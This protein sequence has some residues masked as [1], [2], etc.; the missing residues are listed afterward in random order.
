MKASRFI[1]AGMVLSLPVLLG[2]CATMSKEECVAADWRVVGETDGAAGHDPQSR[3]AA[4]AKSC[5]KAG[6]VPDQTLWYQGFQVGVTRYCT[7]LNGLQEGRAGKT[8]NN[9]CPAG[10]SDGFLR[11]YRLGKAGNEQRQKVQSY[12]SE[13]RQIE[14][15]IAE[16][17]KKL[18]DGAIDQNEAEREIARSRREIHRLRF[19]RQRA[20]LDLRTIER[21]GEIFAANPDM[22]IPPRYS[23]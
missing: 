18:A 4:H 11:G 3:F 5:E 2:S 12:D 8:Y 7:P 9:V 23:Y 17:G 13:I 10:S 21:D 19:E 1:L 15:R 20:E 6:V 22:V 14:F 16:L